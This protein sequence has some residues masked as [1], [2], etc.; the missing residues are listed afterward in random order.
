MYKARLA[1]WGAKKNVNPED[2]RAFLSHSK[3]LRSN[4]AA[5]RSPLSI[6]KVKTYISRLPE[7]RRRQF[8]KSL[9]K[10]L[11]VIISGTCSV[12]SRPPT[13]KDDESQFQHCIRLMHVYVR[14][15]SENN[16]WPRDLNNGFRMQDDVPKWCSLVMSAAW[17]LKEGKEIEANRFLQQFVRHFPTQ[18]VRQD[19]V[20]F[21]FIYTS[22]LFFARQYP[23]VAKYLLQEFYHASERLPWAGSLHPLRLLLVYLNRVGP[24]KMFLYA[25]EVLLAYVDMI[26]MTLGEAYP[27]VQDMLSDAMNRLQ[28]YK[29]ASPSKLAGLAQRMLLAAE[30]QNQHHCKYN[31]ELKIG[32]SHIHL[33]MGKCSAAREIAR[34]VMTPRN[35][36]IRDGV[37]LMKFQMLFCKICE[38]EGK[39]DEAI[40][41][42]LRSLV[43]SI[44]VFGQCSDWAVN[45]LIIYHQV[46]RRAGR[47]DD[48]LLVSQDRDRTI[49]ELCSKVESLELLG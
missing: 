33:Q 29:L 46:L 22:V 24:E 17:V 45:N 16:L 10:P 19:P 27:I 21:A 18:L 13:P 40:L 8:L 30:I 4:T 9:S 32:L 7:D 34:D 31:L 14:G 2:V 49:E 41:Y 12:I 48:A 25:G 35:D 23:Y 39:Q 11:A 38:A 20:L 36:D 5:R 43:T 44:N 42:A 6:E 47:S 37:V 26:H 15:S 28:A 3:P 1:K